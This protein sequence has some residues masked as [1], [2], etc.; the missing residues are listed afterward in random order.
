MVDGVS[1]RRTTGV[2]AGERLEAV[3]QFTASAA[4]WIGADVRSD[5]DPIGA[6]NVLDDR[7][8]KILINVG[9]VGLAAGEQIGS[10]LPEHELHALG[11]HE[12]YGERESEAHPANV[13]LPEFPPPDQRLGGS[14]ASSGARHKNH[15][16][17]EDDGGG[18]NQGDE[19]EEPCW[20]GLVV[21]E[22]IRDVEIDGREGAVVRVDV[23]PAG[24]DCCNCAVSC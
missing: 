11:D 4:I 15:A 21:L 8:D 7:V 3:H 20:N 2:A 1:W 16:H 17:D 23:F 13:P 19:D 18:R 9:E 24:A 5:H 12:G 14:S 22:R 6:D 10:R